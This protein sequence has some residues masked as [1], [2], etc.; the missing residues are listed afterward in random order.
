LPAEALAKAGFP[1]IEKPLQAVIF[2][3]A[4]MPS[5]TSPLS[6]TGCPVLPGLSYTPKAYR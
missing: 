1:T 4:T 6:G 5:R 3:S 2:F